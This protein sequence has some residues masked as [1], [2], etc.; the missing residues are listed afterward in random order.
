MDKAQLEMLQNALDNDH[1]LNEKE[2][3]YV[4]DLVEKGDDYNL[5]DNQAK[6]LE[7]INRKT[8]Y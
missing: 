6:W 1:K 2:F 8:E 4:Y 7:A 5:S 3:N